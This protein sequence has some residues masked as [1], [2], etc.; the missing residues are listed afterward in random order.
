MKRAPCPSVPQAC[1]GTPKVT[2]SW[3][4]PRA[5]SIGHGTGTRYLIAKTRRH[6]PYEA[7]WFRR[8]LGLL[9][10]DQG[11]VGPLCIVDRGFEF[12]RRDVAEVAV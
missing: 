4:V 2:C 5:P 7:P 8:R 12:G 9:D 11:F 6:N 3:T 10:S 1:P